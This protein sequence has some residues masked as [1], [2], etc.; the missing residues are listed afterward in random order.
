[1]GNANGCNLVFK[2]KSTCP[3][4][5]SAAPN[6]GFLKP[7]ER[8]EVLV[9][10][11]GNC[12]DPTIRNREKFLIQSAVT[13]VPCTDWATTNPK[14]II[15]NV[16]KPEEVKLTIRFLPPKPFKAEEE[17]MVPKTENPT[18]PLESKTQQQNAGL[19]VPQTTFFLKNDG[20][21]T[22][23]KELEEDMK[24]HEKAKITG[25]LEQQN[26]FF[27]T[28][29]IAKQMEE[30]KRQMEEEKRRYER[31][32]ISGMLD[33]QST[34]FVKGD[35][36]YL[37]YSSKNTRDENQN[38][39]TQNT[40]LDEPQKTF[41][42]KGDGTSD[43]SLPPPKNFERNKSSPE[44][45]KK[46]QENYFIANEDGTCSVAPIKNS[47]DEM[48]PAKSSKPPS[49]SQKKH[50]NTGTK[51]KIFKNGYQS[52][53]E[54]GDDESETTKE[55]IKPSQERKNNFD[56]PEKAMQAPIKDVTQTTGQNKPN[57]SEKTLSQKST[58]IDENNNTNPKS[59]I[60]VPKQ[61]E[62]SE[63]TATT[64]DWVKVVEVS[65]KDMTRNIKELGDRM[66]AM[67]E[68]I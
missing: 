53:D 41:F 25:A 54:D 4:D 23:G 68:K 44:I 18:L 14:E 61:T 13:S 26:A 37:P 1:M 9:T 8:I 28:P 12:F 36:S 21:Y 58:T 34:F 5:I 52:S 31:Q 56:V 60:E 45:K 49:E 48:T 22:Q 2:I 7:Y 63:N 3:D 38:Q 17:E 67:E 10:L 47:G 46:Q 33:Q 39:E 11:A 50:Q 55:K 62:P 59:K 29:E 20:T 27:M 40:G 43:P 16:P 19:P 32:K 42:I 6:I 66:T 30:E 64:W 65:S 57:L 51:A 35:G 15:R 24:K